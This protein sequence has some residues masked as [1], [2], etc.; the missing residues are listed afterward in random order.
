MNSPTFNNHV[1]ASGN[2]LFFGPEGK[3]MARYDVVT[4]PLIQR[5][6][7]LMRSFHWQAHEIDMSGERASH[8]KAT[9]AER[10]VFKAN[11][12]RQIMLDTVQSRGPALVFLPHV[13]N[14]EMENAI[15]T[16][17]YFETIHSK[18]YTHN[19]RAIYDNPSE[20]FDGIPDI[21]PIVE[22]G[23]SVSA[24]YDAMIA[25]PDK[26]NLLRALVAANALEALRFF[27]SF[28]CIFSMGGRGVYPQSAENV[29]LIAQ[30]ENL[31]LQLV[32]KAFKILLREDEEYTQIAREDNEVYRAIFSDTKRQEKSWATDYLFQEGPIAGLN[33]QILCEA[34]DYWEA[35][36]VTGL[37]IDFNLIP[38]AEVALHPLEPGGASGAGGGVLPVRGHRPRPDR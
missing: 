10:F 36:A 6:D 35:K 12:S 15:Q 7:D 30:D 4:Y 21:L 13:T 29:R 5:H 33:S 9:P 3:G 28:A 17:S 16:W 20:V 8:D 25:V 27:V 32:Q 38:N 31:H 22:A 14:P 2:P 37:G 11:I 34:L 26:R 23:N 1:R 24:F 19:L 18:S